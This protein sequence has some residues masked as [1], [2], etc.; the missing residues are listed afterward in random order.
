MIEKY[1]CTKDFKM[2]GGGEV[3]FKKGKVYDFTKLPNNFRMSQDEKGI[4]Y[5]IYLP[6]MTNYFSK[7]YDLRKSRPHVDTQ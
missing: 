4:D 6:D 3:A 2:Y 5:Y 1:L 7:V